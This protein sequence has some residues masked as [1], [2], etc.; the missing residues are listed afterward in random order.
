MTTHKISFF[1]N[2]L[3]NNSAHKEL[4][5]HSER[6][7][8]IQEIFM[9]VIPTDFV[10]FCSLGKLTNNKLTIIVGTGTIAARL[11]QIIPSLISKFHK[12]GLIEITSIQITVQAN[13][14][15]CHS[16]NSSQKN[17]E[18]SQNGTENLNKLANN[19]PMSPLKNAIISMLENQTNKQN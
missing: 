2:A 5:I 16:P 3:K 1:L 18:I 7:S 14:Y 4:F 13:Y 9:K 19:L 17:L 12:L 6:I 11:K 8:E 10:Q 15:T